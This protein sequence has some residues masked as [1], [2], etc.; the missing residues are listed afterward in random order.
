ME[1]YTVTFGR[2]GTP[3]LGIV[4]GRLEDGARFCAHVPQDQA[5]LSAMTE[6]DFLGV[7]GSVTA[8]APVNRFIPKG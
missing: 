6:E 5:L 7:A 8:G 1:T 4:V 2:E 3:E